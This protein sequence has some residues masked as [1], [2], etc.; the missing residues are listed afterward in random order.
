MIDVLKIKF[1]LGLI[2]RELSNKNEINTSLFKGKTG[3]LLF[4]INYAK[5][6]D[7]HCLDETL[8][9]NIQSLIDAYPLVNSYTLSNG[10][11]GVY[12]FFSYLFKAEIID[13]Q[14]WIVFDAQRLILEKKALEFLQIGN[15]DLL[16]GALG[17]ANSLLYSRD[18]QIVFFEALFDAFQ[19]LTLNKSNMPYDVDHSQGKIL[20]GIVNVGFAHGITSILMFSLNCYKNKVAEEQALTFALKIVEYLQNCVSRNATVSQYSYRI[21]D[22]KPDKFESRLGWCYGDLTNAYA[23]YQAGNILKNKEILTFSQVIFDNVLSRPDF[24]SGVKDAGLCHGSA[25]I[26]HVLNK[27][28]V[29]T[30]DIKFKIGCDYW[31]GKIL[32]DVIL[33]KNKSVFER[34]DPIEGKYKQAYD[35]LEGSAGIGLV[36]SSYLTQDFEWDN[37]IMLK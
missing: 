23:I 3:Q 25:G 17:I 11:A 5:H 9:T 1:L 28:W 21:I 26:A 29:E 14:D 2:H 19:K 27:M 10:K 31:V 16:H 32:D 18:S 6:F 30:Q 34:F 12:W 4:N 13:K 36:L 8:V 35:L 15:Y 7:E 24:Q 37:C 33:E 20:N 22:G